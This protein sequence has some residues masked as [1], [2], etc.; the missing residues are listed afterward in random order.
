MGNKNVQLVLQH[1]Y[2]NKLKSDVHVQ[3]CLATN[4]VVLVAKSCCRKQRVVLL[5]ATHSVLV[6]RFT[7]PRQT[8]FAASDVSTAYDFIQSD[9]SIH[10][11]Q[12]LLNVVVKPE[13]FVVKQVA[14]VCCP[15]YRALSFSHFGCL[16]E[17]NLVS[18]IF[19][20]MEIKIGKSKLKHEM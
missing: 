12:L 19:N 8:C 18:V 16:P 2:K 1:C 4:Q 9:V 11:T 3:T 10:A 17:S 15:C 13:T 20:K 6:A 14:R 7:G 5:F